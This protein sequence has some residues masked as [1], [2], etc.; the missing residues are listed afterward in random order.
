[1]TVHRI[2]ESLRRPEYTGENR[3]PPCTAVNVAIAAGLSAAVATASVPLAAATFLGALAVIALRGY[4]VPGTPTLT[5]R[6]LPGRVLRYFDHAGAE[7]AAV[8][9]P[10]ED[11]D[12]ETLLL[13]AGALREAADD[14]R[15]DPAFRDAWLDE[16]ADLMEDDAAEAALAASLGIDRDRLVGI[17]HGG[18]YVANL[19]GE[20]LGKWPSRAAFVADVAAMDVLADR[21]EAVSDLPSER[22]SGLA[23]GLRVY[24]EECPD[25]GG[26]VEMGTE[27]V[28]SCCRSREV[29][30]STCRS[31]GARLLEIDAEAVADAD[32]P[33]A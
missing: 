8:V 4:L 3:C 33:P 12:V 2:Y 1:M 29:V 10:A 28:E 13:D 31:C 17:G 11:V 18:A 26:V 14:L 30:A 15:L 22:R 24:L 6:Y 16:T 19:D 25:C 5:R 32:D 27:T 21:I 20:I 23:R 9:S 7:T